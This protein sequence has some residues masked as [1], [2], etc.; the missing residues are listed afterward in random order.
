MQRSGLEK[1][2]HELLG[3]GA[4]LYIDSN[5]QARKVR[6]VTNIGNLAHLTLFRELND[7]LNDYVGLSG[8]GNLID[9]NDALV[10]Q[11]APTR[12]NL[13]AAETRL[14]DLFHLLAAI[15]NLATCG[16]VRCWQVLM[17]VTLRIIQEVHR[18]CADLI[19]IEAADVGGHGHTDALV[20]RNQNIRKGRRQQA[21]LFHG[22]VVAVHKVHRI[23]V[24]VLEN[25]GADGRQL[26]LG[27]T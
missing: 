25:L 7:A 22:A 6:L 8:V 13:K 16:K 26:S 27:I 2:S 15:D 12:A 19:Q 9:L 4:A 24:D 18:S 5:A 3:V 21:R 20:G 14:V 11:V 23:L 17:Q 1:L 10:G